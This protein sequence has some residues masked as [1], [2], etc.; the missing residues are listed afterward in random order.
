MLL[1]CAV[2]IARLHDTLRHILILSYGWQTAYIANGSWHSH[3]IVEM[4]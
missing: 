2:A 3:G 4:Y 1:C